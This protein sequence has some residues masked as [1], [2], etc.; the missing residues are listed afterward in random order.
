LAKVLGVSAPTVH[1]WTGKSRPRFERRGALER[2]TGGRVQ[3]PFWL[4]AR[5]KELFG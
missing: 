2:E 1:G 3:A 5:E 4:T